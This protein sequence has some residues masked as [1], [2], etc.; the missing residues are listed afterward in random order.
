ME[1]LP[2][3]NLELILS[4][5]FVN[6]GGLAY[7]S[8]VSPRCLMQGPVH[9]RYFIN[10]QQGTSKQ[11]KNLKDSVQCAEQLQPFQGGWGAWVIFQSFGSLV[12][13]VVNL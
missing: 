5:R 4:P 8:S 2:T 9:R 12:Q 1:D 3:L 10:A 13:L 11:L 6:L 7:L